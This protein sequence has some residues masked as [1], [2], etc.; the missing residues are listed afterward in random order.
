MFLGVILDEH[1]SWKSQI[2]NVARKVTKSVGM[3]YKSSMCLNKTSLCTLYYIVLFTLLCC[4][5]MESELETLKSSMKLTV[6]NKEEKEH[7]VQFLND[8]YDDL[9]FIF[10]M[11]N[12]FLV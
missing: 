12:L 7:G 1:L 5:G 9:A 10:F 6:Q 4:V 3:I 8:I 11:S 2:Q